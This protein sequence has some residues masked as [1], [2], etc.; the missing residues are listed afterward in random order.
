MKSLT[1]QLKENNGCRFFNGDVIVIT[2]TPN[3]ISNH[4]SFEYHNPFTTKKSIEDISFSNDLTNWKWLKG[5]NEGGHATVLYQHWE[6]IG[7]EYVEVLI[8]YEDSIPYKFR[9]IPSHIFE[10]E[11]TRRVA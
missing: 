8:P 3:M 9:F 2:S 7:G 1:E 10:M 4:I 5:V 11:M 6:E